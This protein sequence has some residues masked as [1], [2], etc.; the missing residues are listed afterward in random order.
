LHFNFKINRD[1]CYKI[2]K[3]EKRNKIVAKTR[4]AKI[5]FL[6][7]KPVVK[8]VDIEELKKEVKK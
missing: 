1:G 5:K 6:T 8:K 4:V 3:K 7:K 2:K